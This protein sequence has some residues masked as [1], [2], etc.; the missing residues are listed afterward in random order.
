MSLEDIFAKIPKPKKERNYHHRKQARKFRCRLRK[1]VK[2]TGCYVVSTGVTHCRDCGQDAYGHRLGCRCMK[3][4]QPSQGVAW[5]A[6][7][8]TGEIGNGRETP[9]IQESAFISYRDLYRR[10]VAGDRF[11][12]VS[13]RRELTCNDFK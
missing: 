7:L 6:S 13:D 3:V 5:G 1:W 4:G 11:F 12:D 9:L 8:N 10:L 2:R